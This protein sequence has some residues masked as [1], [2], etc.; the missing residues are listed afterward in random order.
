[1]QTELEETLAQLSAKESASEDANG[2][3]QEVASV[4]KKYS[5]KVNTLNLQV[6]K[7]KTQISEQ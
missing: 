6:T 1:L 4:E 3:K 2:K 5:D 7:L